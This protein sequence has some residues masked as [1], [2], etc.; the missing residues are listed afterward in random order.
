M[1]LESL[2]IIVP[3]SLSLQQPSWYAP[4]SALADHVQCI[5]CMPLQPDTTRPIE[6]L[7]PDAGASLMFE[8]TRSN[9]VCRFCFNTD[10]IP[11]RWSSDTE[12]L[13]VRLKP[14]A[15]PVLLSP[16][17]LTSVNQSQQVDEYD[18][19][20]ITAL[21]E[22]LLPL[23]AEQ[24]VMC[25]QQWLLSRLQ[26]HMQRNKPVNTALVAALCGITASPKQYARELGMSRRTLERRM[27]SLMGITPNQMFSFHRIRKA[28]ELLLRGK[29]PLADI[30]VLAGFYDQAHF[31]NLFHEATMESPAQYRRRKLSQISNTST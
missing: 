18:L 27:R 3:A 15:I 22:A 25:I 28:R 6:K 16:A 9:V 19:P 23:A 10:T 30:A 7:Y 8:F 13:S 12:H 29:T 11:H 4:H 31:T 1:E 20:G 2:G 14:G 21:C 26:C 5:W 17:F 24:R